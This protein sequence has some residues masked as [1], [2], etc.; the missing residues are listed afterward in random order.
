MQIG[1]DDALNHLKQLAAH[2]SSVRAVVTAGADCSFALV[3]SL[4][5]SVEKGFSVVNKEAEVDFSSDA[6][7]CNIDHDIVRSVPE[8]GLGEGRC[9]TSLE[10]R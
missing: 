10:A 8:E 5:H 1:G 2:G 9:L 7:S 6:V 4:T 3:G